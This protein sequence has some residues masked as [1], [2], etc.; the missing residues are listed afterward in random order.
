MGTH[1]ATINLNT[2][3]IFGDRNNFSIHYRTYPNE[4]NH[5]STDLMA[6]C[7]IIINN[8]LIGQPDEACYL[9]TWLFS[10]TK[11]KNH[12]IDTEH[13]LFPKAF[14]GLS[15]REIFETIFKANQLD[16][17]FH[18]DFLYL[19]QLDSVIW[20]N[21]SFTLDE[22]IDNYLFYFYVKD[23]QI[24]FLIEDETGSLKSNQRSYKFLFHTILLDLFFRTV[25][26]ITVFLTQHYPY[27]KD[28]ISTR[29][30]NR[31]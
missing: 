26:E 6:I 19:P 4:Y 16:E 3:L 20:S 22:T 27:L 9:P 30:F 28:N 11:R 29:T 7:H 18:P 8:T 23:N 17:E 21:H 12:I 13:L 25:E 10:L 14:E 1:I 15:N 31:S 5:T 2:S 24:T